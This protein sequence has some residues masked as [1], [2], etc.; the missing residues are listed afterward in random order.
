M[1]TAAVKANN[2]TPFFHKKT[3]LIRQKTVVHAVC[4][5]GNS[6]YEMQ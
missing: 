4:L 2:S 6:S 3:T 1:A 5:V